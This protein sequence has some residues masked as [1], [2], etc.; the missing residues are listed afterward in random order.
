MIAI[1]LIERA[2]LNRLSRPPVD[3]KAPECVQTIR[4]SPIAMEMASELTPGAA[5]GCYGHT[6]EERNS[7]GDIIPIM[8]GQLKLHSSRRGE[9]TQPTLAKGVARGQIDTLLQIEI[10]DSMCNSL[11]NNNIVVPDVECERMAVHH[12]TKH[13]IGMAARVEITRESSDGHVNGA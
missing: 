6:R 3:E 10:A 12:G 5:K 9:C 8:L 4:A 11:L 1:E 2:S 13:E 7:D